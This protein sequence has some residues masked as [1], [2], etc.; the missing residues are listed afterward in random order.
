MMN[1]RY[2]RIKMLNNTNVIQ[3]YMVQYK[4]YKWKMTSLI[5]QVLLQSTIACHYVTTPMPHILNVF[6]SGARSEAS[7]IH[8]LVEVE[9]ATMH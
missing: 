6:S 8:R 2:W 7:Y 4:L 3:L 5:K 1:D 9:R